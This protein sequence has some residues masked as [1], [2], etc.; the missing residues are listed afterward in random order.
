MENKKELPVIEY[1]DIKAL[2]WEWIEEIGLYFFLAGF[3]IGA[4]LMFAASM[5]AFSDTLYQFDKICPAGISL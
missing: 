4:L 1:S 5:Y 3:F 2:K